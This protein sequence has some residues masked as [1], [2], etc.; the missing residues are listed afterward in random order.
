MLKSICNATSWPKIFKGTVSLSLSTFSLNF[1]P[2][3]AVASPQTSCFENQ[4]VVYRINENAIICR[5]INLM[6]LSGRSKEFDKLTLYRYI[7][8]QNH[9]NRYASSTVSVVFYQHQIKLVSIFGRK[10]CEIMSNIDD[11]EIPMTQFYIE[12]RKFSRWSVLGEPD[13]ERVRRHKSDVTLILE[14]SRAFPRAE[15]QF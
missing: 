6:I 11:C 4:E 1:V 2:N 13:Q 15:L 9:S 5:T 10:D 3:Q 8:N 14:V 12:G 7:P